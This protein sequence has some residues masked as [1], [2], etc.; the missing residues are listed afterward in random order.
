MNEVMRGGS[1]R[2]MSAGFVAF[3]PISTWRATRAIWTNPDT[4]FTGCRGIAGTNGAF[5]YPGTGE[6]SFASSRAS[7]WTWT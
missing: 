7:P 6:S 4:D 1:T 2:P 5:A 3:S